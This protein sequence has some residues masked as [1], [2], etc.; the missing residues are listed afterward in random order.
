MPALPDHP[1]RRPSVRLRILVSER[2]KIGHQP[3]HEAIVQAALEAGLGGATAWRGALG[4]GHSRRV[5]SAKILD[6]AADLPVAVEIIDS[7]A[8]I[9]RF[10]ETVRGMLE[11]GGVH[12]LATLEPVESIELGPAGSAGA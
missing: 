8:D 9:E 5:H 7:P 1:G 10:L 3:A 2:D 4:F 6:L 11:R 12:A